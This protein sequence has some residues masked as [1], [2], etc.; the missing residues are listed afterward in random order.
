VAQGLYSGVSGLAL[1]AGLYK[2]TSGLWS[3]AS[4]LVTGDGAALSLNFLSG[5]LDPR[6]TFTRGTTATFVGSN[7]LIQSAAVNAPRFDYDP[8]TLQPRGLLVEEQRTNLALYSNTFSDATWIAVVTKNLVANNAMGPDGAMSASTITDNSTTAFEGIR[9]NFTVPNDTTTYVF[10]IYVAKTSG[11]TS[12]TFGVNLSLTGG[13][14]A[15][16]FMRVNTDNGV[17]LNGLGTVQDAGSFWRISSTITNNATGNVALGFSVYPATAGNGIL[18]DVVTATGSAV[19]WGAQIEVATFATSYIPTVASTVT[20]S[21]DVTTMTGT[22]FSQWYNQIE[23]T[24]VVGYATLDVTFSVPKPTAA[25]HDGTANNR[26]YGYVSTA[27]PVVFVTTGGVTQATIT[28]PNV[29]ANVANKM[30]FAYIENNIALSSNGSAAGTDTSATI[31][32]VNQLNIGVFIPTSV[33][34]NGHIRAITYY[35]T[36]LPDAQLQALTT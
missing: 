23:G 9:Q 3:G 16:S 24:F 2:D 1:G 17:R 11:G 30:A 19:I 31:P 20:R 32:T 15:T 18:G 13:T 5:A 35:N 6:I 8:A 22:N 28:R 4:G 10:S 21:A 34:L 36:R 26:I 14:S 7:G 12:S 27:T 33:Y 25:V 29:A